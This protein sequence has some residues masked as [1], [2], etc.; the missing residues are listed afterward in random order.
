MRLRRLER[1]VDLLLALAPLSDA[2]RAER[3]RINEELQVNR[4]PPPAG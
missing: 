2:D 3:R 4:L 1:K